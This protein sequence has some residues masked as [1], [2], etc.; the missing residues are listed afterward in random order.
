MKKGFLLCFQFIPE[1]ARFNVSTGNTEAALAT[2]QRIA[3][4]NGVAM[5]EGQLREP[6]KVSAGCPALPSQPGLQGFIWASGREQDCQPHLALPLS[7]SLP[8]SFPN[9]GLETEKR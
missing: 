1:S 8:G 5:P 2:L 7:S 4:M 9:R 3:S 6:A